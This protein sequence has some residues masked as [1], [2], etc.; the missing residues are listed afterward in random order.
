[1][2]LDTVHHLKYNLIDLSHFTSIHQGFETSASKKNI[3]PDDFY[4]NKKY[5]KSKSIEQTFLLFNYLVCSS[6]LS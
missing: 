1:M 2:I 5:L 4:W 6:S 3:D